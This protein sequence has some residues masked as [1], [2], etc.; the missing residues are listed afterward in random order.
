MV[1]CRLQP[2]RAPADG[3]HRERALGQDGSVCVRHTNESKSARRD[4]LHFIEQLPPTEVLRYS[5]G[6]GGLTH[7]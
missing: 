7:R 1:A 5:K 6:E 3:Q 2:S 4:R